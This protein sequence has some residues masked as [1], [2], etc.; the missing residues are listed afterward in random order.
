MKRRTMYDSYFY[1]GMYTRITPITKRK[2]L[3]FLML[4]FLKHYSKS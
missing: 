2:I 3:E 1:N 4:I